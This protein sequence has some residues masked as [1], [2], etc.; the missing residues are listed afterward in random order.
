M[1]R[2]RPDACRP[3]QVLAESV[4]NDRGL[5]IARAGVTLTEGLIRRLAAAGIWGVFVDD[6]RYRGIPVTEPL[7][8]GTLYPLVAYLKRLVH[9]VQSADD[10]GAVSVS[11]AEL[12]DWAD[13][14][15][16]EVATVQ[17]PFLLYQPPAGELPRWLGRTINTAVLAARTL[18][19]LGGIT[20]ARN[21]V[22][23]ALLQDLGVWRLE[24]E[25][26]ARLYRERDAEAVRRHVEVSQ[27]IVA[28]ISGISSIVRGIVSQH[29]ERWDGSG[30][31]QGRKGDEIH[32]L[33]RVMGVVDDYLGLVYD[34]REACLPHEAVEHLMAGAGFEYDHASVKAFC[35]AAPLYP[36]GTEVR[37]N[38]GE[39]AVVVGP[40]ALASRPRLRLLTDAAGRPAAERE[41]DLSKHPTLMIVD[42]ID[43]APP[44]RERTERPQEGV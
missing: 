23:A 28:G 36:P 15:S 1:R 10:E 42:V 40:T 2:I 18:R 16:D 6:P 12:M 29:H 30:L 21:L 11:A 33:A 5:V 22:A 9:A 3:G 24:G 13:R 43:A 8:P 27:R 34:G 20:Q 35:A 17:G 7:N 19:R 31:P 38:T 32:P 39:Q 4:V 26:R 37:L 41:I 44:D 25:L 14:V